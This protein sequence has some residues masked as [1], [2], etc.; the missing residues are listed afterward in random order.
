VFASLSLDLDERERREALVEGEGM[1]GLVDQAKLRIAPHLAQALSEEQ[2]R[3]IERSFAAIRRAWGEIKEESR[4]AER[5]EL[6]FHLVGVLRHAD[7][8]RRLLLVASGSLRNQAVEAAARLDRRAEQARWTILFVLGIGVAILFTV[9]AT[10]F[11]LGVKRPLN[12]A[13]AAVSRIAEGDLTTP[14]PPPETA[15]EFGR[16]LETLE[17]LRRHAAERIALEQE[18]VRTLGERDVRREQLETLIGVFRAAVLTALNDN[19]AAV[20]TM[21]RATREL[22]ASTWDTRAGGSRAMA[23]SREVS[24]NVTDIAAAAR[25]LADS[26]ANMAQSA[27]QARAAVDQA[28]ERAKDATATIDGLSRTADAI[29]DVAL[30]I[31]GIARQTNLLAL[32][33]TIEAARAGSAGR[34]FAVVAGEVKTLAGQ[35]AAATNDIASRIDEVRGRVRSTVDAIG[36]ITRNTDEIT[37]HATTIASAVTEQSQVTATISQNIQE[38]ANWTT[39]LTGAIDELASIIARTQAPAEQVDAATA[40]SATAT[41]RFNRLVDDFLDKVRAA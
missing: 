20:E 17:F 21:R 41:D 22:V 6:L 4:N 26:I 29:G 13:I 25:Q 35:T 31:D 14:V 15:D 39:G 36:T 19:A 5:A 37:A 24:S 28:T 1:L 18:R 7:E 38:A 32:N 40:S 12:T 10:I 34:G 9:A 30:F 2:H 16:I 33:A 27:E 3:T 11:H 23:V 8:A